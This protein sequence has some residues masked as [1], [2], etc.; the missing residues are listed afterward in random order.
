MSVMFMACQASRIAVAGPICAAL[1]GADCDFAAAV[2]TARPVA[3]YR[4]D[5]TQGRAGPAPS[6][7]RRR[8][9]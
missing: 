1:H 4:L 9:A 2:L 8:A 3:Y 7:T 6:S 5:G